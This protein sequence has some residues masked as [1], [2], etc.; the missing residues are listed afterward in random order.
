MSLL[1]NT[2][3]IK[4][5]DLDILQN[6]KITNGSFISNQNQRK[7][8]TNSP[9]SVFWEKEE[10]NQ[11][12]LLQKLI[13]KQKTTK[14]K[15]SSIF[16]FNLKLLKWNLGLI[17]FIG[18]S[19]VFAELEPYREMHWF[20]LKRLPIFLKSNIFSEDPINMYDYQADEILRKFKEQLKKSTEIFQKRQN[21]IER[22]TQR[23][24]KKQHVD[25]KTKGLEKSF[26]FS[27][28]K[29]LIKNSEKRNFEL[30]NK[31]Y[32]NKNNNTY[33][34]NKQKNTETIIVFIKSDIQSQDQER[35]LVDNIS[36]LLN[37]FSFFRK[38]VSRGQPFWKPFFSFLAHTFF[39]SRLSKL[40]RRFRHSILIMHFVWIP[41][42]PLLSILFSF[43]WKNWILNFSLNTNN[44]TYLFN[45]LEYSRKKP[46]MRR[47]AL[48]GWKLPKVLLNYNNKQNNK[49]TNTNQLNFSTLVDAQEELKKYNNLKFH[50]VSSS[51]YSPFQI[52]MLTDN[53]I[54]NFEY[55]QFSKEIRKILEKI[56][57]QN[58]EFSPLSPPLLSR[59]FLWNFMKFEEKYRRAIFKLSHIKNKKKNQFIGQNAIDFF[60]FYLNSPSLSLHQFF[61]YSKIYD[62]SYYIINKYK[63][64][65]INNQEQSAQNRYMHYKTYDPKVRLYRFY[66]NF[67]KNLNDIGIIQDAK[68]VHPIFGSL[69]CEI[70]SGFF[71]LEANKRISNLSKRQSSSYRFALS[72]TKN[73]LL[74]GNTNSSN[75][76]LLVQAF[77][78]ETGL[79]LFMEDAKRLRRLG[80]RGINKSTKRL[81]KLFE[82]AQISSPSIVFLEDIDVIGSKRRIM[83]INEEEE[84]DNMAIRSFFSKLLYRKQHNYKS[85]SQSF[86][87]Q[88]LNINN[89]DVYR[90]MQKSIIPKSPIPSNLIKYQLT[91]RKAF[92]NYF[93]NTSKTSYNSFLTKFNILKTH[94]ASSSTD[95]NISN[96]ISSSPTNAVIIWK[97]LKSKLVTQKKTIKETP[98]E[99][100]PVD[101]MRSIPLITYSIR[102]KVAKLTMLAIYTMNTQLRLVKDLIKLMEKIQYESYKGFI[103]FGTTNKLSTLDP[104]LRRPG[105]F[106]ETV[107]LPSLTVNPRF[108]RV[109]IIHFINVLWIDSQHFLNFSRTFD[110][111]NASNF[112]MNWNANTLYGNLVLQDNSEKFFSSY[113][114]HLSLQDLINSTAENVYNQNIFMQDGNNV[115]KHFIS[116]DILRNIG[117]EKPNFSIYSQSVILLSLGYSKASQLMIQLFLKKQCIGKNIFI[118]S[119][120]KQI[121]NKNKLIFNSENNELTLWSN[122]H[123]FSEFKILNISY[124][125]RQKNI[126]NLLIYYFAGKI[127]EFCFFN[128]PNNFKNKFK[129]YQ[130]NTIDTGINNQR[131]KWNFK[132][133]N[134]FFDKNSFSLRSLYGIQPNWKSINSVIF[135]IIRTSCFY[136]KNHLTSKLFYLDDI[137]KKRQRVF[138][139]N[140][141]PS[142]LFEYF[143]LN[144]E[145]FLKRNIITLEEQLHKQQMQ[146]YLLNL[147]KK[148]LRKFLFNVNL[149]EINKNRFA[150]YINKINNKNILLPEKNKKQNNEDIQTNRK[151]FRLALFRILFNEL[152]SLDLVA[153]RPTAM[154]YYYHK[155]IVSKQ[156]FRKYTHK[157]WNWH[158]KKTV[159]YLEEF[160]YLD[161]FPYMDKQYNTRRQRWILTNG[162]SA[163]W[164]SQEKILYYQIYEQLIIECFQ[165]AY[166]HLD[167]HREMLDYL[168]QFL[169]TKQL[170]TEIEWIFFFKRFV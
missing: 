167:R 163:Y 108:Q 48:F 144:T 42:G 40:N 106:D 3:V 142:L 69:F 5:S 157:W 105:R 13:K 75:F 131:V 33:F 41:F 21:T 136:S 7:V 8:I 1:R 149:T 89:Q 61:I 148:P 71:S 152:G 23:N 9:T 165:R 44:Y 156:R 86:I 82:I 73:I 19:D 119:N 95:S 104:S 91:R 121:F 154:N 153:L 109:G 134:Y 72:S 162:Y 35:R 31:K 97:L 166:L 59:I 112:A 126:K 83:K 63:S 143:H 158:F 110:I 125:N 103:V 22:K 122:S 120:S 100:I 147:Q 10:S 85:L 141:G 60:K 20:F 17:L 2:S 62:Q 164:L 123:L 58:T 169:L 102:V 26:D 14:K 29:I 24:R 168:A 129:F 113:S 79:K 39:I 98:W 27:S 99:H 117:F 57:H 56:N 51:Y 81:E 50:T 25:D 15:D 18:E 12:H 151:D 150:S 139:E 28:R 52:N 96:N 138:S 155:K 133:F 118:F 68:N 92:S 6:Y 140:S 115:Y 132:K 30:I 80:R 46:Q 38:R 124:N 137:L 128:F 34:L 47:H 78:A 160:Q 66:T 145:S 101:S 4:K 161:F 107:Y 67:S 127:G 76:V 65:Y 88:N 93:S 130:K 87:N 74:V 49:K 36:Y 64:I 146:K 77:A 70:Y 54:S 16:Q 37:N 135:F 45:Q 111:L 55:K 11:N 94:S 53:E 170:L 159:D 43:L 32:R 116:C 114:H 84:D 90:N